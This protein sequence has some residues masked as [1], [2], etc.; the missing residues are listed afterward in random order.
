[1]L[2]IPDFR[3]RFGFLVFS[4]IL[5]SAANALTIATSLGSAVWTGSSVNLA[6]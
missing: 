3:Q 4:I 2:N 5:N 6:D 1:M